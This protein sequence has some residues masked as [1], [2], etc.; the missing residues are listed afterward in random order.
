[1]QSDANPDTCVKI[2]ALELVQFPRE[3]IKR[4]MVSLIKAR[5]N[6]FAE[7]TTVKRESVTAHFLAYSPYSA[8][9]P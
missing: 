6:Y 3:Y 1:M 4:F 7:H 2:D 8:T 9:N 5:L